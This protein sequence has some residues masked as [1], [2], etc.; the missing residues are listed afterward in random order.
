M[1]KKPLSVAGGPGRARRRRCLRP[2][3]PARLPGLLGE[4]RGRLHLQPRRR[5]PRLPA[6]GPR[7]RAGEMLT[8]ANNA[9]F[10][11]INRDDID[12]RFAAFLTNP[13]MTTYGTSEVAEYYFEQH[14][15]SLEHGYVGKII[16]PEY[17]DGIEPK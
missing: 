14:D 2:D 6:P 1:K 8:L 13:Q 17:P 15:F 10:A 11:A 16:G 7:G 12:G 5:R 9:R 3:R 4:D